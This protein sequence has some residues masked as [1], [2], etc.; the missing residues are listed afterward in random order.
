MSRNMITTGRSLVPMRGCVSSDAFCVYLKR[1]NPKKMPMS[2]QSYK[3][4]SRPPRRCIVNFYACVAS[5]SRCLV[6]AHCQSLTLAR[7]S[8]KHWALM[9][10]FFFSSPSCL[11]LFAM[12]TASSR[13]RLIVTDLIDRKSVALPCA[14]HKVQHAIAKFLSYWSAQGSFDCRRDPLYQCMQCGLRD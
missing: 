13:Q 10:Q 11:N 8:S 3:T 5:F 6:S 14:R 1:Q 4:N 12:S 9:P 2:F 7:L